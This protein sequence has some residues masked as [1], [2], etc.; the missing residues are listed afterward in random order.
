MSADSEF[1]LK[2]ANVLDE[3]AK[4]I[5]NAEAEKTAAVKTAREAALKNISDRYTEATGEE[6]PQEVFDKISS[7]GEDVLS[8]VKHLLEKT[9]GSTGVESLGRSGEKSA[10]KQPSTKKEAADAAYERFGNFIIS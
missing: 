5:D 7:S 2:V 9:A 4:V 6:I 3:A 8:T 10:A 1:L